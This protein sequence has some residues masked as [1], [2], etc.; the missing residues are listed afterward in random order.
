[1]HGVDGAYDTNEPKDLGDVPCTYALAPQ[2]GSYQFTPSH[3]PT[4]K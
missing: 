3:A 1:M 2:R 4:R